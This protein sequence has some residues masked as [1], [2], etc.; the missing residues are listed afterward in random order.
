M[1]SDTGERVSFLRRHGVGLALAAILV[2]ATALRLPAIN[3]CMAPDE[4]ASVI[5]YARHGIHT[6]FLE[7]YWSC[8]HPLNSLLG[9]VVISILGE[10]NWVVRLPSLVAGLGAIVLMFSFARRILGDARAALSCALFLAVSPYPIA[11]STNFRGYGLAMFF[12]VAS[13][14]LLYE[15]M[16]QPS[17]RKT[18]GLAATTLLMGT[19]QLASL[20][21]L[22]VWGA[23][24]A[25]FFLATL[26]RRDWRIGRLTLGWFASAVGLSLGF[27]LLCVAYAPVFRLDEA[28]LARLTTGE[29]TKEA[30]GFLAGAEQVEWHPFYRY[31]ETLTGYRGPLFVLPTVVAMI[32]G[33]G[34]LRHRRYG[35]GIVLAV[36]VLPI[37]GMAAI[38][39]KLEP[40]YTLALAPF[41]LL[42]LGT[43]TVYLAR[44]FGDRTADAAGRTANAYA[45]LA[46]VLCG[47]ALAPLA[48]D[49]RRGIEQ[50]TCVIWDTDTAVRSLASKVSEDDVVV[51]PMEGDLPTMLYLD[52]YLYPE[53]GATQEPSPVFRW[54]YLSSGMDKVPAETISPTDSMP[55]IVDG[56]PGG[57]VCCELIACEHWRRLALEGLESVEDEARDPAGR[58]WHAECYGGTHALAL[59]RDVETDRAFVQITDV[60]GQLNG[61]LFSRAFPVEPFKRVLFRAYVEEIP[62]KE[63]GMVGIRFLD[64]DQHVL[65]ERYCTIPRAHAP[66]EAPATAR[67]RPN[68]PGY[69][70]VQATA[71]APP[72]AASFVVGLRV[73]PTRRP[74][75]TIRFRAP[76]LWADAPVSFHTAGWD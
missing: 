67:T 31:T 30:Y 40:R 69:R 28:I 10:S 5:L 48:K 22:P 32:G 45:V 21:L 57:Y 55:T 26:T 73:S 62:Y 15:N 46:L 58:P 75:T 14:C 70:F 25:V 16:R 35:M 60:D 18:L 50:V 66:Q 53:L 47:M 49:Y 38:R 76:E 64:R 7:P 2:L 6:S 39:L 9:W 52:W 72:D 27:V 17:L 37:A 44:W 42:A 51:Y 19:S 20:M 4:A 36:L 29:W 33:I 43:G 41:F 59:G 3:S 23:A 12:A 54:W 13:A 71:C 1:Q 34:A 24:L 74:G 8:N 65:E 11:Y 68:E 63:H 56:F 61:G